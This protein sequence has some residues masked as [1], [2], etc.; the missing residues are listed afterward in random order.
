MHFFNTNGTGSSHAAGQRG[1]SADAMNGNAVYYTPGKLI[2]MGGSTDYVNSVPTK[3]AF[4]V[5]I[6]P[7]PSSP[8]GYAASTREV[9]QMNFARAFHS[10]VV[11]PDGTVFV[12][13]GMPFAKIFSDDNAVLTPELYNPTTSTFRT[14]APMSVPRTY[15]SVA[16]LMKD[17]RVF[18]AG[19]G[20]CANIG[21]AV[22]HFDAQ[23]YTPPYL[24]KSDNTPA[25][26]P[27]ILQAPNFIKIGT[28]FQV[29]A[30]QASRYVV[31]RMGATTH[32]VN[33]DQR[34][35]PLTTV[36]TSGLTATVSMPRDTFSILPGLHFLFAINNAGVPSIARVVRI[37][38]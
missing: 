23:I 1:S 14:L 24:L 37:A 6:V 32:S 8:T 31:V 18:V 20:L 25:A 27:A 3:R 19:G 29:R 22:N 16:I 11:L 30:S 36:S 10:S 9:G 5:T 15:H 34:R 21:C 35:T 4:E 33:N 13:G 17:G 26:R 7:S 2:T 28:T 12:V 38:P